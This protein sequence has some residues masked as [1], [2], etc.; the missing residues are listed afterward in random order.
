[1]ALSTGEYIFVAI[2]ALSAAV[3]LA[4]GMYANVINQ[5]QSLSIATL[6][7][8][9]ATLNTETD[10][11]ISLIPVK[12]YTK[13]PIEWTI[14]S[15]VYT[16]DSSQFRF[17]GSPLELILNRYDNEVFLELI[18]GAWTFSSLGTLTATHAGAI[19]AEYRTSVSNSLSI[20]VQFFTNG[21]NPA[22][23]QVTIDFFTGT[24][25]LFGPANFN[26]NC[27]FPTISL[28][29]QLTPNA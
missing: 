21:N 23:G 5:T 15:T 28:P 14:N 27:F 29:Y 19:P 12:S 9:V 13:V 18:S 20:T 8:Q 25:T 16:K 11:L 3:G 6:N 10:N 4:I 1:M 22:L 7:S 2:M 24:I 26:G 17:P